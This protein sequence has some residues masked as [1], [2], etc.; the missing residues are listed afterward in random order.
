MRPSGLRWT[1]VRRALGYIACCAERHGRRQQPPNGGGRMLHRRGT[2]RHAG[3]TLAIAGAAIAALAAVPAIA[4]ADVWGT[5]FDTG[6]YTPGQNIDGQGGWSDPGLFDANVIELKN[7]PGAAGYGFAAKALQISNFKTTGAFGDQTFTPSV[8]DE[9]GETGAVGAGWS[10]GVRQ[11]Q[12]NARYRIGV[13]N[14]AD[15]PGSGEDR[16]VTVSA[17]RGDGARMTYLRFEDHADGIH[18]FFDDVPSPATAL[19]PGDGKQHVNFE[20]AD[21]ATLNRAQ[22]HLVEANTTFVDGP[23][24]GTANDVVTVKI[25]GTLRHTGTTWENYFRHD[26]EAAPNQVPTVDSLLVR[27]G[28]TNNAG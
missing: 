24:N 4:Q 20:E 27:E 28:G 26:E 15:V 9:A 16:H 14:P 12:F 21:I 23:T 22:P 19:D 11:T 6:A 13:A 25:D 7:Y 17:D 10:G 5:N 3:R 8:A 18:V 2:P 1:Q